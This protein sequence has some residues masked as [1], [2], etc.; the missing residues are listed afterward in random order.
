[1]N[2]V[3]WIHKFCYFLCFVFWPVSAMYFSTYCILYKI[4]KSPLDRKEIKPVDS[5]GNLP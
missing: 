3:R 4:H 2:L 5:K 1:M